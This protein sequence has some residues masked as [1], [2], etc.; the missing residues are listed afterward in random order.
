MRRA[1]RQG[2]LLA[3]LLGTAAGRIGLRPASNMAGSE[4]AVPVEV[5]SQG[6][7]AEAKPHLVEGQ[8]LKLDNFNPDK[9]TLVDDSKLVFGKDP[10]DPTLRNWAD[11]NI[12]YGLRKHHPKTYDEVAGCVQTYLVSRVPALPCLVLHCLQ[13]GACVLMDVCL[14]C[15]ALHCTACVLI[16]ANS[17]DLLVSLCPHPQ[18]TTNRRLVR[19]INAKGGKLRAMGLAHSWSNILPDDNTDVVFLDGFKAIHQSPNDYSIVTVQGA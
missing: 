10:S 7:T 15:L 14:P 12:A 16:V 11:N 9:Y 6:E 19:E 2:F 1:F 17:A 5:G 4:A 18:S 3:A 13:W 8:F